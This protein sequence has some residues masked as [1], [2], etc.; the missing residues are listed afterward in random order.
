MLHIFQ[1]QKKKMQV[2]TVFKSN[3][4]VLSYEKETQWANRTKRAMS[5]KN[6]KQQTS[7]CYSMFSPFCDMVKVYTDAHTH[8]THVCV[9]QHKYIKRKK[10]NN[11]KQV[12]IMEKEVQ[13]SLIYF[14]GI[15]HVPRFI[16]KIWCDI[17]HL[18]YHYQCLLVWG[19]YFWREDR[20]YDPGVMSYVLKYSLII[21]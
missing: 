17:R 8:T 19:P 18:I 5:K 12:L 20:R 1:Q 4:L 14:T 2:S 10:I 15:T 3:N 6:N 16:N 13:Q 11:Y 7:N 9:S 21:L